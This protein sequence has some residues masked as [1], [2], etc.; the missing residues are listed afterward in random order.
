[1]GVFSN[2]RDTWRRT[3]A[4]ASASFEVLRR[5]RFLMV[6]P[7]LSLVAILVIAVVNWVVVNLATV[8]LNAGT[9]DEPYRWASEPIV[10]LGVAAST[11]LI[12]FVSVYLTAALTFGAWERFQGNTPTFESCISGANARLHVIGPWALLAGTVGLILEL[13]YRLPNIVQHLNE[14]VRH[15]PVIGPFAG[16]AALAARI[17]ALVLD[18]L[19]FLITY[20]VVP[21]LVVEQTGPF[22]SCK[23]SFQL[24]RKTWGKSLIA[25]V[26]FDLIGLLIALPGLLLAGL[27]VLAG[28]GNPA[29]LV[30]GISIGVL[31]LLAV[32]L[33]MSAIVGIFKMALYLYVTTGEIPG[34][35][36]GTGL[37]E[38]FASK[39]ALKAERKAEKARQK[40]EKAQQRSL[41][42]GS[43]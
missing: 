13:L 42:P 24:F 18:S 7:A 30:V 41:A 19:W 43:Y 1:M 38:V 12:T 23:R 33:A 35:F 15:I 20:L 28:W 36:E 4:L 39:K 21:I 8:G 2:L 5:D 34:E 27:V 10:W 6:F 16:S 17:L 25:Q 32:L 9:V 29:A 14:N 31:W 37:E 26:A 3:K 40:A 11:L 22:A